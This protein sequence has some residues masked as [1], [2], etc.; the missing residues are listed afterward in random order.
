MNSADPLDAFNRPIGEVIGRI[1]QTTVSHSRSGDKLG[2]D[3]SCQR[4]YEAK[5]TAHHA[6]CRTCSADHWVRFMLARAEAQRVYGAA[7]KSHIECTRNTLKHSTCSMVRDTKRLDLWCEPY[8]LLSG[9][10][11]VVWWWLVL[12]KRQ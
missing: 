4:A 10:P 5:Q 8:I 6:W 1:V 2:F 3:A 7:R 11:K 9:G 12:R